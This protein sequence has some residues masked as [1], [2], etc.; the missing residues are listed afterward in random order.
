MRNRR[1]DAG[2]SH[3]PFPQDNYDTHANVIGF[4]KQR[5]AAVVF[6]FCLSG[7]HKHEGNPYWLRSSGSS[8]DPLEE[9]PP[10]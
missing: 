9:L 8:S 5:A 3:G 4:Q 2:A 1:A 7:S 6:R 10:T